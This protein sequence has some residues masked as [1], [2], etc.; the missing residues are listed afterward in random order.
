MTIHQI[1]VKTVDRKYA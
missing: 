1:V